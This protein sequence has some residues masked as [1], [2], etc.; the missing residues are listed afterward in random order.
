MEHQHRVNTQRKFGEALCYIHLRID[1]VDYL[2][3]EDAMAEGRGRAQRQPED[4]P[5]PPKKHWW[6]FW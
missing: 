4:V 5:R 3:T 6:K 2:M 1:G